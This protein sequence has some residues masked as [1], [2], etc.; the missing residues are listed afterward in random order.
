MTAASSVEVM[1]SMAG[2][3][4]WKASLAGAK[5][6]TLGVLVNVYIW[7]DSYSAPSK[8]VRLKASTVED[9]FV[10]GMRR[11]SIT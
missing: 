1:F 5:M 2:P 7:S 4:F 10:G 11:E 3:R 9:T 8:E 6:V